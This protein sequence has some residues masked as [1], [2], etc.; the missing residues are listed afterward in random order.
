MGQPFPQVALA[1]ASRGGKL[2]YGRWAALVQSFVEPQRITDP[3]QC[4]ARRA[5]EVGQHL[6]HKL[7]QFRV[8]NHAFPLSECCPAEKPVSGPPMGPGDQHLVLISRGV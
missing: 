8:V 3:D 6:S 5:A 4:N 2:V 7:M 1:D